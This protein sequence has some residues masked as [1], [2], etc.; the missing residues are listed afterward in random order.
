MCWTNRGNL[1]LCFLVVVCACRGVA[2]VIALS[3]SLPLCGSVF[4]PVQH[5]ARLSPAKTV[6]WC[7][8]PPQR[9]C[10]H[11]LAQRARSTS[12]LFSAHRRKEMRTHWY[13]DKDSQTDTCSLDL[14]DPSGSVATIIIKTELQKKKT[15]S[16]I[17]SD[18][19]LPQR[20]CQFSPLTHPLLYIHL[21]LLLPVGCWELVVLRS[22]CIKTPCVKAALS[23][24]CESYKA[25]D[26][27]VFALSKCFGFVFSA[28]PGLHND[29]KFCLK[30]R[31]Y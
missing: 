23:D 22:W 4:E 25:Q 20:L 10:T 2:G 21:C 6:R 1:L 3:L 19:L 30:G 8:A 17:L 18:H 9:A 16:S 12:C 27:D 26:P 11:L 29:T 13:R 7:S 31:S 5:A 28:W 24:T 15:A 14:Q